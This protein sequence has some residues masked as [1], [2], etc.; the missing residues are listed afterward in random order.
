MAHRDFDG[1]TFIKE[2]GVAAGTALVPRAASA[3]VDHRLDTDG[4]H[5]EVV[6]VFTEGADPTVLDGHNLRDGYT[7][8]TSSRSPTRG[9]RLDHGRGRRDRRVRHR[10]ALVADGE[11]Y[12]ITV[13]VSTNLDAVVEYDVDVAFAADVAF[14]ADET[15][16]ARRGPVRPGSRGSRDCRAQRRR[17]PSF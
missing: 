3:A 11:D 5:Q 17:V 16:Y 1:R 4:G 7:P 9:R 13:R 15:A 14:V 8:S 2:A 12:R 10:G 6:V